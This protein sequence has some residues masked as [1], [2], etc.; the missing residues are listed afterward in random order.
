M[1][2]FT[3]TETIHEAVDVFHLDRDGYPELVPLG[4]DA[5]DSELGGLGPGACGILA[6]ATGVGKS[7]AM[8]AAMLN[9][10][11]KVG[12]VSVEDGADVVGTRILSGL[13]GIDSLRIRRKA[14]SEA[15]LGAIAKAAKG[16][17]MDHMY[18]SYPIAGHIS[19]VVEDIQEMTA[20]G[21]KL[22]WLD[23]LQEVQGDKTER[24]HEVKEV[25]S[26]AHAAAA[27]G[28][29]ALM[30]LSQFR[31]LGDIEK[32]PEIYHLKESGDLENKARIIVLA[33]R[34]ADPD[35]KARIRFRLAKSAYGGEHI[36]WDMIRDPSGTL[37][38]TPFYD[39]MAGDF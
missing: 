10:R 24:R 26:K 4:L 14:L 16:N 2:V 9:S 27:E 25:M 30:C 7:S 38:D 34:V 1:T 13:T 11:I 12:A 32:R 5:L 33:H 35:K 21:C 15:E 18:F 31:R 23:Y 28:G 29:A 39:D 8:L 20:L 3:T 17:R 19:R 22:I 36:T 6:A 37:K